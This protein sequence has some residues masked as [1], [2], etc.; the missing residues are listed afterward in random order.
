M[1]EMILSNSPIK[2]SEFSDGTWGFID[3]I[4]KHKYLVVNK[5]PS[6]TQL[7]FNDT[8]LD[9]T[10]LSFLVFIPKNKSTTYVLDTTVSPPTCL[11]TPTSLFWDSK[12]KNGIHPILDLNETV[13]V[14]LDSSI[15]SAIK[16][17]FDCEQARENVRAEII[18]E[19]QPSIQTPSLSEISSDTSQPSQITSDYTFLKPEYRPSAPPLNEL[20]LNEKERIESLINEIEEILNEPGIQQFLNL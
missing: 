19:K 4:S 10:P 3:S 8:N 17:L 20:E 12:S 11:S 1:L 15:T 14:S 13:G 7:T 5:Q 9:G 18:L 6:Y 2:M 16:K